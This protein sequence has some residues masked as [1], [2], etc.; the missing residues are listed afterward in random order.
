MD[1]RIYGHFHK[2][3]LT[4]IRQPRTS[5]VNAKTQLLT[6]REAQK[7][8]VARGQIVTQSIPGK[9]RVRQRGGQMLSARETRCNNVDSAAFAA[10]IAASRIASISIQLRETRSRRVSKRFELVVVR[11]LFSLLAPVV[12]LALV[13]IF[14]F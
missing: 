5:E 7:A 12:E 1:T 11:F 8:A 14:M 9:D 13:A 2:A 3:L 4:G 10:R 6:F